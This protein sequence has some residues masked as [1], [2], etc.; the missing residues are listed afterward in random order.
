MHSQ[1][2]LTDWSEDK[3]KEFVESSWFDYDHTRSIR[4][5]LRCRYGYSRSQGPEYKADLLNQIEFLEACIVYYQKNFYSDNDADDPG[6]PEHK[7][8]N[9]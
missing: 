8:N 6:S 9:G 3:V 4:R 2:D 7:E 5:E 1:V